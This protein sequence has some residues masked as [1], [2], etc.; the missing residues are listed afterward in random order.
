VCSPGDFVVER[1]GA[2]DPPLLAFAR[3]NSMDEGLNIHIQKFLCLTNLSLA[4]W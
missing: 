2:P 4:G 3:I 1:S